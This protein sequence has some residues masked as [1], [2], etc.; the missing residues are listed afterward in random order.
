MENVIENK[1]YKAGDRLVVGG[2]TLRIMGVIEGWMVCRYKRS[3]PFL[4]HENEF[5]N[6]LKKR[7]TL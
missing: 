4:V 1:K 3:A 2:Y 7:F 6:Y 5:E